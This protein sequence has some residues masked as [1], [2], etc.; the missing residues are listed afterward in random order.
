MKGLKSIYSVKGWLVVLMVFF[1]T[2]AWA[3]QTEEKQEVEQQRP[4][5]IDSFDV[6]RDYRPILADAVKIRRSPDMTNKRSYMPKLS[7]QDIMDQKLDINT[8]LH[9]LDL[10]ERPF[11]VRENILPNYVKVGIGNFNTILAEGYFAYEDFVDMRFG[12]F[13]KHLSQKGELEAQKFSRQELGVFGRRVLPQ[14]TID[15]MLGYNRY[16]TNFY[17]DPVIGSGAPINPDK[18]PQTFNDIYF[19]GELTSNTQAED[20]DALSYSAKVN[21][22]AYNSSA[23]DAKETSFVLS[24]Y[25]NK[26]MRFFNAGVNLTLDINN[27]DGMQNPI[28]GA[29]T[30]NNSYAIINPYIRFKGDNYAI[31]LGGNLIPE[32]GDSTSFNIFPSAQVDFSLVPGYVYLF[33]GVEGTVNKGSYKQ[34]ATENPYLGPNQF[35]Q[36]TVERLSF[37]GGI[38]GNAGA[39]FGYKAKAFYKQLEH[40]PLFALNPENLFMYDVIY[41]GDGDDQVKHVGIEGEI[42]VRLSELVNLGGRLNI[43]QYTLVNEQEAWNL[44]KMRLTGMARFTIS[45]KLYIDAEALFQGQTYAK[46]Y[47]ELPGTQMDYRKETLPA[48]F[49]LSA[50]AEY[51][52]TKNLG[53]F[54]KANNMLNTTY[55]RYLYYPK[56]GFNILGGLNFSF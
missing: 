14:F 33:G 37:H 22:Y 47:P 38:K 40:L 5:T 51:K 28:T 11:S 4:V 16:G 12:G 18:A 27:M 49:D 34:L 9:V 15:G 30:I 42:N 20:E 29:R 10:K 19:S 6:V 17:G 7:Y 31:T 52:A 3:Q 2:V 1:G 26:R 8:G 48:F 13:V 46:A 25:L 41:D 43:D 36:N 32:F 23:F 44:P 35:I 50:S 54:V 56:V 55:E 24:S 21:A 39:T 53:L 45:E